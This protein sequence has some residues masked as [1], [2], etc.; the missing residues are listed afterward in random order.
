MYEENYFRN[1]VPD[2]I[3]WSAEHSGA[4]EIE[5]SVKSYIFGGSFHKVL[6]K[7]IN[8]DEIKITRLTDVKLPEEGTEIY[9]YWPPADGVVMH[10]YSG[11]VASY[12]ENESGISKEIRKAREQAGR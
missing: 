3:Q 9:L 10:A 8:G 7:L 12:F 1:P 11:S 4:F 5:G 6:V 2:E